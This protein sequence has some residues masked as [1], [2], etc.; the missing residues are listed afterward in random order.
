MKDK[1]IN[2]GNQILKFLAEQKMKTDAYKC[3]RFFYQPEVPK[4]IL[5]RYK[6]DL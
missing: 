2:L 5:E 3:N 4:K 1:N 6:K